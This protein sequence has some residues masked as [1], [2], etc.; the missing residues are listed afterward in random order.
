MM[1]REF[2]LVEE[3]W[4][5]VLTNNFEIKEISLKDVFLKAHEFRGLAGET[6]LQD[7]AIL[8]F[9][10]AISYVV[11]ARYGYKN[12]QKH[13]S[14]DGVFPFEFFEQYFQEWYDRFWL[15]DDK[16]PFYQ[17]LAVKGKNKVPITTGKIIGTLFESANKRRLFADRNENGR[18]L[19]FAEAARWLL[20]LNCFDD[21]AAQAP[22][23]KRTHVSKLGLVMLEGKNLFETLLLNFCGND[24]AKEV[25]P[26]WECDNNISEF[27]RIVPIPKNQAELLSLISRRI[28]LHRD[29]DKVI[30]YDMS[31]GDYFEEEDVL[32]EQMTT[33]IGSKEKK[34]SPYTFKA[35][36]R[37]QPRSIIQEF[38]YI[39]DMIGIIDGAEESTRCPGVIKN[40]KNLLDKR[41]LKD[42]DLI[43][44]VIA[45][46]IYNYS[47]ATSLP[48]SDM[49]SDQIKCRAELMGDNGYE[50]RKNIYSEIKKIND[51]ANQISRFYKNLQFALGRRD[52][53]NKTL[54]S[55]ELDAKKCFLE[56]AERELKH[57]IENADFDVH[58]IDHRLKEIALSFGKKIFDRFG[59]ANSKKCFDNFVAEIRRIFDEDGE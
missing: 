22:K 50:W 58:C 17:S 49:F 21:I 9:L 43:S 25:I 35:K 28:Y 52:K 38:E 47:Q 56:I 18:E 5:C 7:I 16:Y 4:I 45:S 23:P 48:V 26:S 11:F 33:W 53:D 44:I 57:R 15:F 30:S 36:K 24:D 14:K 42:S 6:K 34:N 40:I 54:Q 10:L 46:V 8:R 31:G 19:S 2:N 37:L 39:V 29:G 55:G 32:M 27:N 3:P 12:I 1:T 20:H 51:M 13:L 41:I 59:N